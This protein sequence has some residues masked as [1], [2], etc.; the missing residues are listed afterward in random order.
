MTIKQKTRQAISHRASDEIS[1]NIFIISHLC[2]A[3]K[4]FFGHYAEVL[5]ITQKNIVNFE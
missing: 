2:G 4:V 5:L 1:P 3:C